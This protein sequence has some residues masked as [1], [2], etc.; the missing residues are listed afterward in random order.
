MLLTA[1]LT[2][3]GVVPPPDLSSRFT[4][5][6]ERDDTAALVVA[7]GPEVVLGS[8]DFSSVHEAIQRYECID[9]HASTST[10]ESAT[11]DSVTYR[12]ELVATGRSA[13]TLKKPFVFPRVWFV[14]FGRNGEN[15]RIRSARTRESLLV[16]RLYAA[17]DDAARWEIL[18]TAGDFEIDFVARGANSRL[19]EKPALWPFVRSLAAATGDLY[20]MADSYGYACLSVLR[21]P[22]RAVEYQ[23]EGRL[24]AEASG[25]PDALA[26]ADWFEGYV[27]WA[28]RDVGGAIQS[29]TRAAARV[30]GV[31]D[32]RTPITGLQFLNILEMGRG[33][34]S[35]AAAHA[36]RIRELARR[37]DWPEGEVLALE[38]LS[39]VHS[40][41]GD[42]AVYGALNR[43]RLRRAT[44]I[45]DREQMGVATW[46]L[47]QSSVTEEKYGEAE[48]LIHRAAKYSPDVARLAPL[49]LGDILMRQNR[50]AEAEELFQRAL[51]NAREAKDGNFEIR[52]LTM[53]SRA[54]LKRE[55]PTKALELIREAIALR[56]SK[57][58]PVNLSVVRAWE[59]SSAEASALHRLGRCDE[60]RETLERAIDYVEVEK[61]VT[62]GEATPMF[63]NERL[64]PLL[65]L[66]WLHHEQN[67]IVDALSV[68]ER[69]KARVLRDVLDGGRVNLR[70]VLT[71][72]ERKEETALDMRVVELNRAMVTAGETQ[73]AELRA[74]L[75]K[76]RAEQRAFAVRTHLAHPELRNAVPPP[77]V[78]DVRDWLAL[79]RLVP[80][81]DS[82]ILDYVVT[83]KETLL[84]AVTRNADGANDVHAFMIPIEKKTLARTIAEMTAQMEQR[85]LRYAATARELHRQLLGPVQSLLAG[86]KNICVVPHGIVWQ[87][88][89]AVLIGTDGKHLVERASIHYAP[90]LAYLSRFSER[91]HVWLPIKPRVFALGNPAIA[92]ASLAHVRAFTRA[93]LGALP[94]AAAEAREV[95]QLYGGGDV[96]VEREATEEA[97]KAAAAQHD[98]LHFATHGIAQTAQPLYSSLVLTTKSDREDGLLEAREIARMNLRAQLAVLS[99]CETARGAIAEGEGVIG[100]SWAFLIAGCPRTVVTQWR[101]ASSPT[102]KA[103]VEF[104]RRIARTEGGGSV[105]GALRDAQLA[106]RRTDGLSHP[107]YW[108]GFVLVGAGW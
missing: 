66:L 87:V 54:A 4:A 97:V 78:A 94:D 7:A 69:I 74:S 90:S 79:G 98:I 58:V 41:L 43:E 67:A 10:I 61:N 11:E 38:A 46:S 26:R 63:F 34:V 64:G 93:N 33:N 42:D 20:T 71:P 37:F 89:F 21:E 85:D 55:Q 48:E 18:R 32:P 9:V 27:K 13:G 6:L 59:Q 14:T 81:A 52:T 17:P 83:S 47:V 56:A 24:L 19:S 15:W 96:L 72:E 31:M 16:D 86:K 60:A 62:A 99:A 65:A 92:D 40:C 2:L 101:A 39:H 44:A 3:A 25:D 82:I 51:A 45:A 84:F 49:R 95:G 73:S 106:L 100:L 53:L 88:P 104:H 75:E 50:L 1:L 36:Y 23:K 35:G 80:S 108:G 70:A 8:R 105:A 76:A 107:F 22:A 30:D 77:T 102:A 28:T 91:P 29:F 57:P 103:M 68:S 12:V 5:L